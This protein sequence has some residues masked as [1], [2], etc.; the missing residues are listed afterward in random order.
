MKKTS[1]GSIVFYLSAFERFKL[2]V[3]GV[4]CAALPAFFLFELLPQHRTVSEYLLFA[5]AL[6][7]AGFCLYMAA[8]FLKRALGGVNFIIGPQYIEAQNRR[9]VVSDMENIF[10]GGWF[11]DAGLTVTRLAFARQPFFH[12]V[13]HCYGFLI[14]GCLLSL[15]GV[16]GVIMGMSW[17]KAGRCVLIITLLL[18]LGIF[19]YKNGRQYW[20]NVNKKDLRK[21]F[22]ALQ[23]FCENNKV[24]FK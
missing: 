2:F 20:L 10:G 1:D 7:L 3:G 17:L 5:T 6:F 11:C 18:A 8:Y 14:A 13:M 9:F 24:T 22:G 12:K 4:L 19:Q 21:L 16:A 23:T 15:G